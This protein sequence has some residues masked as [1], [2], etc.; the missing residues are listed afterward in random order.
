MHEIKIKRI[1][2]TSLEEDGYRVLVDRLWPRGV[3][4][5]AAALDLWEKDIA[6]S[7][8]LRKAVYAG[9]VSWDAF[10]K[11]YKE[12]IKENVK[13]FTAWQ[14]QMHEVL[15][16][17]NLTLLTSAK[18]NPKGHPYVLKELLSKNEKQAESR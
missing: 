18:L 9:E 5:E 7:S 17:S 4:K 3:S 2:D 8:D 1:Y 11:R 12:E 14:N 16:I 15:K 6:P 13:V 10:D